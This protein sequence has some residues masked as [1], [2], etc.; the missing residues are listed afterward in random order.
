MQS[1]KKFILYGLSGSQPTRA[2]CMYFALHQKEYE[3][4]I[5]NIPKGEHETEEYAKIN[6]IQLVPALSHGDFHLGEGSAILV[7][8]AKVWNDQKYYSDEPKKCGRI[9]MYL[10]YHSTVR[11]AGPLPFRDKFRVIIGKYIDIPSK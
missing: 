9:H 5:V 1:G 4:K 3:F 7:Y 11:E 10:S 8:L 2:V 6:P